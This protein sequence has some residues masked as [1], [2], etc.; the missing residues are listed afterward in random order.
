MILYAGLS[1]IFMLIDKQTPVFS[2]IRS[3]FSVPAF[4]MQY[5]VSWPIQFVSDWQSALNSHNKLVTENNALI[6]DQLLLRAEVGRL[7][8]IES[9]NRQLRALLH[10]AAEV[11]GKVLV[12]RLLA[13]GT[14]SFAHQV[15]LNRGKSDGLFVGQLVLDAYGVIGQVVRVNLFTSQVLLI[16]D[17]HSGVPIEVVRSGIRAIAIGDLYTGSL[18]L[19]NVPQT[20]DVRVGDL[21]ITSGMGANYPSGYPVGR[22]SSIK[23]DA[24][25]QFSTIIVEP[26]AHMNRSWQVLLVWPNHSADK[27]NIG[28]SA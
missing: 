6:E 16:N 23:R 15:T 14:D 1:V 18:R 27:N 28:V 25:L 12:A 8:S 9:E 19:I 26:A 17:S 2:H 4:S 10:S 22:V 7:A 5:L 3:A 20:A 21:L 24:G 13:V 11:R